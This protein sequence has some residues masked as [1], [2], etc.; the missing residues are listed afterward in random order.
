MARVKRAVHSK[1]H[2]RATLE[3]AGLV[4]RSGCALELLGGFLGLVAVPVNHVGLKRLLAIVV[5]VNG[6]V[7]GHGAYI[8]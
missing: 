8:L 3:R 5:T 2:R 1:K 7:E 4:Q 6:G